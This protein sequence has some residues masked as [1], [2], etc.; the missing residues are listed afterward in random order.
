MKTLSNTLFHSSLWTPTLESYASAANLTVQLFDGSERA[1][2]DPVNPTPMFQL[3]A[4][5]GYDP[6]LF[7]VCARRCLAQS[8]DRSAVLVSEFYGLTVI[9]TSLVLD[10]AVVGAAVG[11]YAFVDFSQLSE[12]QLLARDAGITFERVWTIAREQKPVPRQRLVLNAQLLQVLGDAL[13]RENYR[14]RQYEDL[15]IKLEEAVR[16]RERAYAELERTADAGRAS[17]ERLRKV[18]KIAAANQLASSMAHEINNPLA[19]VT[20]VLYLLETGAGLDEKTREYAAVAGRELARVSRIV[21]Q[22]LSYH[23]V[24]TTPID[25]DFGA[26]V[27]ESLLILKEKFQRADVEVKAKVQNGTILL[28]FPGELRQVVDNLLLNALDAMPHGGRISLSMRESCDWSQRRKGLR[29]T[30]GDTGYGIPKQYRRRILE[31][32]FTTKSDKGTGLGLWILSGILAKHDGS[33]RVRS[34]DTPGRSGTAI[35]IFLPY[36]AQRPRNPKATG[37]PAVA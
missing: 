14:T 35:S 29:L 2:L 24:G 12:V 15:A 11:G 27:N 16:L 37:V 32:F 31:P 3:F 20:N 25:L 10:G 22:S 18:E 21:K 8:V 23:R 26:I 36:H 30:V 34:S 13:L 28:G 5:K 9:G 7:A 17:E 19:S 33:M 4:E 1:V 6:G